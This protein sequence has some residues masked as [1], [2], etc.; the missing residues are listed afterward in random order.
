MAMGFVRDASVEWAAMNLH[1]RPE[2]AAIIGLFHGA[3]AYQVSAAVNALVQELEK[4]E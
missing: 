1:L 4:V 2:V 3:P